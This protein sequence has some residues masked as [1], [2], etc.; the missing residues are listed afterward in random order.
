MGPVRKVD[1]TKVLLMLVG[2]NLY[3]SV[4]TKLLLTSYKVAVQCN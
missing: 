2:V 4:P 1:Q 3:S